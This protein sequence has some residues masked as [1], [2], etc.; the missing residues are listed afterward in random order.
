MLAAAHRDQQLRAAREL[1]GQ[2]LRASRSARSMP[3]SRITVDDLGV[4]A[5]AGLG[6]GRDRA[7]LR[8][9]ERD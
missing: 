6:A 2:A 8:V 9:G 7:R 1:V 3:T 4:D 5:R